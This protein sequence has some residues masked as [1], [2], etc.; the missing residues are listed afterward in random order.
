MNKVWPQIILLWLSGVIA[1]AQLAKFSALAPVLRG[2]FG[3]DLLSV[4]WLISLLEV[5]GALFGFVAGLALGRIGPR[6]VL[7]GGL[8]VLAA[9]CPVEA[10]TQSQILLY[11]TRAIEGLGYMLVV[12]S[13]PTLIAALAGDGPQRGRAMILWS[14]FVPVGLGL[15]TMLT[16]LL[17]GWLGPRIAIA[18]WSLPCLA[19]V[20]LAWRIHTEATTSR[21]RAWPVPGAWLLAAGFGCYTL[22]LCALGGLLPTL[23]IARQG[24]TLPQAGLAAGLVS[25][26]ALP[27][28]LLALPLLRLGGRPERA[29]CVALIIAAALAPLIPQASGLIACTALAMALVVLSGLARSFLFARLP[30]L[31]GADKPGD[32]RIASAQG[33]LTQW[34]ASGALAGPPLG[35][36]VVE[37]WGWHGLGVM[38]AALILLLAALYAAAETSENRHYRAPS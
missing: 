28:S 1:A 37:R 6:R 23:L 19:A 22:F 15:G 30:V 34:G 38:I 31:S 26:A 24:A 27:G 5:G 17:A 14:S 7:L 10:S 8:A 35:A 20:L 9:A 2:L 29:P 16:S 12:V 32:P 36:W 11:I 25:L 13:A 33:L 3:L 21:A 4:G 18:L